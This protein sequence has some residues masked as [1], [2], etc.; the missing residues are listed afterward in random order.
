M[1][2]FF[3]AVVLTVAQN[4]GKAIDLYTLGGVIGLML[5][6]AE[7]VTAFSANTLKRRENKL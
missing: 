7:S 4:M 6:V 5:G 1:K 3:D 2:L